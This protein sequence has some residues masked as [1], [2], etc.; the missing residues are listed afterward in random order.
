MKRFVVVVVALLALTGCGDNTEVAS[1][2]SGQPQSQPSTESTGQQ[3]TKGPKGWIKL[4]GAYTY[5]GPFTGNFFCT[6]DVGYMSLEGQAPYHLNIVV[7]KLRDGT[8]NVAAQ[9]RKN[10]FEPATP[11]DPVFD[12]RGLKSV[13]DDKYSGFWHDKGVITIN[14]G[15]TSGTLSSDWIDDET[16]ATVHSDVRWSDCGK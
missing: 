16:K 6:T 12:V 3:A 11:G 4:A 8:F 1:N 9:D 14:G 5:D 10:G 7:N 2:P 13:T 15:G